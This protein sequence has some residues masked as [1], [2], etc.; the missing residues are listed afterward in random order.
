MGDREKHPGLGQEVEQKGGVIGFKLFSTLQLD[1]KVSACDQE[2]LQEE[3]ML[4]ITI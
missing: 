4:K 2:Q 1:I 3:L